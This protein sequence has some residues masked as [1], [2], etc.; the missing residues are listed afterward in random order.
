MELIKKKTNESVLAKF[1][2]IL[3]IGILEAGGRN[4]VVKLSS[5]A[6][7]T[8]KGAITGMLLFTQYWYWFPLIQMLSLSMEPTCLIGVDKDLKLP[9]GFELKCNTKKSMFDYP[10][11]VKQTDKTEKEKKKVQL[12][13]TLRAEARD[14]KKVKEEGKNKMD[15]EKIEDD[16]DKKTP[17][18]ANKKEA[19]EKKDDNKMEEEVKGAD[20]AEEEKPEEEEEPTHILKN[21]CRVLRTQVKYIQYLDDNRYKPILT[22]RKRGYVFLQ[23]TKPSEF[24]EFVDDEPLEAW[25]IPPPD[26]TFD[27]DAQIKHDIEDSA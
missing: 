6:K 8:K 15:E 9:K 17:E 2:C 16:K 10:P 5:E 14:K 11:I 1:G 18:D 21:P 4:S 12:S 13:T 24:E 27:E 22:N 20:K 19:D 3:A 26:F 23:D 25:L 7:T